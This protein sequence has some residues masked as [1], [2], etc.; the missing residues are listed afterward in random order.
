MS[1]EAVGVIKVV[2]EPMTFPSGFTKRTFVL[3]IPDGNYTQTVPFDLLKDK[4]S[5][6]D[7]SMIGDEVKVKFNLQGRQDQK[8]GR[9]YPSNVAWNITQEG[10]GSRQSASVEPFETRTGVEPSVDTD[11]IPF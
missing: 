9:Y 2:D 10:Q 11:E 4:V 8:S 1:Y 7:E 5:L 6:V 3:E